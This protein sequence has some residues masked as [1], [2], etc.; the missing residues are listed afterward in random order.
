MLVTTQAWQRERSK[1]DE[2]GLEADY[3]TIL[4]GEAE[5]GVIWYE[6]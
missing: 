4:P 5:A 2:E 6:R 1:V 3:E